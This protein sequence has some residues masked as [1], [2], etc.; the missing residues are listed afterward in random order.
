LSN[1]DGHLHLGWSLT[2]LCPDAEASGKVANNP[3]FPSLKQWASGKRERRRLEALLDC[4]VEIVIIT[5]PEAEIEYVNPAFEAATGYS[6]E[7]AIRQHVRMLKSGRHDGAFY[8]ELWETLSRGDVWRGRLY[9]KRKDGR[10][11]P[12]DAL[13]APLKD[14]SGTVTHY[15]AIKRDLS[16]EVEL[17][18]HLKQAQLSEALHAL[19]DGFIHN[20]N[21]VMA[22]M[23]GY[24]DLLRMNLAK[25]APEN[26]SYVDKIVKSGEHARM[27]LHVLNSL[28]LEPSSGKYIVHLGSFVDE[29]A[30]MLQALMPSRVQLAIE[31]AEGPDAIV[32]DARELRQLVVALCIHALQ[33]LRD[34]G[35]RMEIYVG[36]CEI[37][38]PPHSAWPGL[39]PGHYVRLRVSDSGPKLVASERQGIFNPFAPARLEADSSGLCLFVVD[40]IVRELGGAVT[41]FSEGEMGSVIDIV[42][43]GA[44]SI[45]EIPE[46]SNTMERYRGNERILLLD[47]DEVMLATL[48]RVL[49]SLGYHVTIRRESSLALESIQENPDRFDLFIINFAMPGMNGLEWGGKA[50]DIC[51]G[52]PMI[53]CT[54]PQDKV[55][56]GE[57]RKSGFQEILRKPASMREAGL[58]IRRILDRKA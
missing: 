25:K 15:A 21:N 6:R 44:L 38:E 3:A 20:F 29:T 22:A 4:A 36:S 24:T 47:D 10:I 56:R 55:T 58:Q 41:V 33:G 35:G 49:L 12:E 28:S 26:L 19:T 5:N 27:L 40:R 2:D 34:Q 57:A 13:I 53:L 45:E 23:N 14:A 54:A 30:K 32:A 9:N 43:P 39:A 18:D 46:D 42:L 1:W 8:R 52:V 16:G 17:E 11:Y 7:E 50:L 48:R 37:A 51:T 31:I